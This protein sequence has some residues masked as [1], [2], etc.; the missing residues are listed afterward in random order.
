MTQRPNPLIDVSSQRESCACGVG[1]VVHFSTQNQLESSH[2]LVKEALSHLANFHYRSGFNDVTSESDGSG[3]RFY[4]LST[5]FFNK[6]LGRG[7][8]NAANLPP[9]EA[10]TYAIGQFFLPE[11]KIQ[12]DK[13]RELICRSAEK[14]GFIIRGWRDL[15]KAM[16][17]DLL[18]KSA[19]KKMP[20][21]WQALIQ[22]E[23][24]T[25]LRE[26]S[27]LE[28]S[29][30]LYHQ[31]YKKRIFFHTLSLSC[32]KIVYKGMIPP[33]LLKEI[34]L[35]L[36]DADFTA[37]AADFHARFATNTSTLW[38]NSQPCPHFISH[39]GELN[40]APA[41][42]REMS[43][44]LNKYQFK[45]IYPNQQ[46]SDSMQ[47]DA[48]LA[49]Q[50]VMKQI[51][52]AE[53]MVRLM[54]PSAPSYPTEVE[55]MLQLWSAE[56]TPYNGPAF[57]VAGAER[58]FMAKLDTMG[59]RPS[60][61]CRIIDKS[62]RQRIY[63]ASD[64]FINPN[65]DDLVEKGHLEPGGMLLITPEGNLLNTAS[66][67]EKISRRYAR[68]N[69]KHFTHKASQTLHLLPQEPVPLP[70][71]LSGNELNRILYASGWDF[72]AEE[73]VVRYMAEYGIERTAAMGDD[74]NILYTSHRPPHPSYFFHQ[75]FAQVSAPPLDS[76]KER[77]RFSLTVNL[78]RINQETMEP[79]WQ[80]SSP[81]LAVHELFVI[82]SLPQTVMIP[83]HNPLFAKSQKNSLLNS[84]ME[85][86]ARLT[87]HIQEHDGGILILSDQER[88][89]WQIALPDLIAVAL[90]R[91]ILAAHKK[92]GDFAVII[93]S[94]QIHGP[95]QA[96]TLLALGAKALYPRG[97]YAKI[98]TLFAE[99]ASYCVRYREALQK[100]L[101]K[102]MGKM[103]ITDVNNYISGDLLG[104]IGLDLEFVI[105]DEI[106]LA[107][108]FPGITS[109]FKGLSL[110]E[111]LTEW[112][113]RHQVAYN[114]QHDFSMLPRSGYYMPE[115][116]GVKH[117]YGPPVINAFTDWMKEE[118]LKAIT[119]QLH[120]RLHQQGYSDFISDL[121]NY[122]I[123]KGFIDPSYKN[124]AGFYPV[125]YLE[126]AEPSMAFTQLME[127]IDAYNQRHPTALR[128]YLVIKTD[129]T[130]LTTRVN[131]QT[132]AEIRACLYAGSMSQGALTV[133]NPEE[134]ERL[135][136]H[137]TLTRGMNAVGTQ[138]ASGEGGEA[139]A[140][141]THRLTSTRSK[142]FASGRFGISVY[143]ILSA[144]EIEIKIAQGAKPGEGGELPGTKVSIRF[145]AQ[146]GGMPGMGFI[147]PPP[148]HDIYSIE[149]LEQ[150][151]HDLKSVKPDL[152]IAVKLVSSPGIGPIAVGVAKA[153]ADII[154]I[155]AYSG[156][157]GA[158]QQSSIKH[159]GFPAEYG[160]VAVDE[161]L[162]EA[163]LRS[164]VKLRCSGGFKTANDLLIATIL[165]ADLF[166]LGTTAMLTLGCKMLRTCNLSCQP[167]VA[168]DGEL[169]KGEQINTERYFVLLAA[170]IRV[171]LQ[172]LG[173]HSL[174]ELRGRRNLLS[175]IHHEHL[176][177]YDLSALLSPT[178]HKN[179]AQS[180]VVKAKHRRTQK[181]VRLKEDALVRHLFTLM[182]NDSVEYNSPLIE[183]ST[184]DR[185]FGARIIG[186]L[187]SWLRENPQAKI[188]INTC[189]NAGQSYGFVNTLQLIHQGFVQDG[190]GK[191]MTGGVLV[192]KAP[193]L[194]T[195]YNPHEHTIAGNALFYGARGGQGFI[196]GQ[197]G[198]RFAILLKGAEVVVEGVGDF[199]F[200]Y[201]TSGTGLLLGPAGRG[202][203][204]GASGGIIIV[205]DP[206]NQTQESDSVRMASPIQRANYK[207]VIHEL[208]QEHWL[209]T[210][211]PRARMLLDNFCLNDYK[212]L[213]PTA[214]DQVQSWSQVL[215][216]I[217]TYC[218]RKSGLTRGMEVWLQQKVETLNKPTADTRQ[219][220][221]KLL[222]HPD[223]CVLPIAIQQQLQNHLILPN[224]EINIP[225]HQIIHPKKGHLQPFMQKNPVAI[226]LKD[227]T[228]IPDY[229]LLEPLRSIKNYLA[230]LYK[231]A[232]GC[233]SCRSQSC[234]GDSEVNTGC[235]AGK[236]INTI[237]AL[238]K[239]IG[240]IPDDGTLTPLQWRYLRQAFT[241]QIAETPFIAYTG[242]ACPAPCEDACT[243]SIPNFG[244]PNPLR[245]NKN[246]GEPVSIRN[247]E[248]A[249]YLLG[250]ALGWFNGQEPDAFIQTT[251]ALT[252][253]HQIMSEFTPPFSPSRSSK[254]DKEL[255]IIGSGPAGMQL[256][257]RALKDG[258]SVRMY[259]RSSHPG[260]LLIDGI[261]AHKFDKKYIQTDFAALHDM[262]LKLWTEREIAFD[263]NQG[264]FYE[265][266]SGEIIAHRDCP[267]HYIALCTGAGKPQELDPAVLEQAGDLSSSRIVHAIQ[268]LKAANEL[269]RALQARVDYTDAEREAIIQSYLGTMDPRNKKIVVIGGGDTA[270]D[271]IRW[272]CRYLNQ[273][274]NVLSQLE[275]LVR[276]P[277]IHHREIWDG[278]PAPS[279]APTTENKMKRTEINYV[280]G[281]EQF[282]V[283]PIKI[284]QQEDQRLRLYIKKS[285]YLYYEIITNDKNQAQLFQKL[286]RHRKPLD[287]SK[288]QVEILHN[289]ELIFCALGFSGQIDGS[290]SQAS[291]QNDPQRV[292]TVGDAAGTNLI[293]EAQ[294]HANEVYKQI[295]S[296]MGLS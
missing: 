81:V 234:A 96:S 188:V 225:V 92:D 179:P 86:T 19:R 256:A 89:Q 157:T 63:V 199:A 271:I 266:N 20:A 137:E 120:R 139:E 28:L 95:H 133:A 230:I 67:L 113:K 111:I 240:T 221:E 135:K 148:H 291:D 280:H 55:A 255:I 178:V 169:F 228:G 74:T 69:P 164:L 116:K 241:V 50:I 218:L 138:S 44:E 223:I 30:A 273:E 150:L 41:N 278:Y 106:T 174:T 210:D 279:L 101:L 181:L 275:V 25:K 236:Q 219:R 87:A 244:P 48:D 117:G 260:G 177:K 184:Q 12:Q 64:D 209:Y 36:Q 267:Q 145:A 65:N 123:E 85:F 38:S 182:R 141:L 292:F 205:Y 166:E 246:I 6:L 84:I 251:D 253:Y 259:E 249:L 226:R 7:E 192:V 10:G 47:F 295:K 52:L 185:S 104:A 227:I 110:L 103:G 204:T 202:L 94:Y 265:L 196:N 70:S 124:R 5:V 293:I 151:I 143:Q 276:G 162:R 122:T 88:S 242:V 72:E 213:I 82:Q 3:I 206:E 80:L 215:D 222:N 59:L 198:H 229:R 248:Y 142:Q 191:S 170:Q 153:G 243:E 286:P 161:A 75:L 232:S 283:E 296:A 290:L 233:S 15:R 237:N 100:C 272:L 27:L 115:K 126:R 43:S 238:L 66:I 187:G 254:A 102:T 2:E 77:E 61:W 176:K 155:A 235:P 42:A 34:Y 51:T 136:A 190:C 57:I 208:L 33:D 247:I 281:T 49:N 214:M 93:D 165:G 203:A 119:Y 158:A 78:G 212:V 18:S 152:R 62:G 201:M 58:H 163:K 270:Q 268:F 14:K 76:I 118:T 264:A 262:G 79:L 194:A 129:R 239:Q 108:I 99:P 1:L 159:A 156:G 31:A 24:H 224:N 105:S 171:Q 112:F 39:N 26:R 160:L 23:E 91:A 200:E 250:S 216:I 35:D 8:F 257:Y 175:L 97:A 245:G 140:D 294:N 263:A 220:A 282:L 29:I 71:F 195:V 269:A 16:N 168:T 154:N 172:A 56:R 53:A 231:D 132:T 173:Y 13:A 261:P 121:Q 21:I 186:G 37:Y 193:K 289:V 130:A 207:Q 211:S 146:R 131:M 180:Q 46:L 109:P 149:D 22:R 125:D 284:E 114:Y 217:H 32:E 189:G 90:A 40:S 252:E 147:S 127:R 68:D 258:I 285:V 134:P 277:A 183:L 167:G 274:D 107:S 98:H 197:A 54:Q 287:D 73:Q 17:C 4:G 11:N 45:G 288:S 128:D 83:I 60:R 144:D 9:L